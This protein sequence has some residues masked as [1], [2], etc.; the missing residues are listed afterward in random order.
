MTGT[1]P[2]RNSPNI[3]FTIFG[4]GALGSLVGGKLAAGFPVILIGRKEHLTAIEKQGLQISGKS[5]LT[6]RPR[7][8]LINEKGGS[9]I[10]EKWRAITKSVSKGSSY[11]TM[12]ASGITGTVPSL[13]TRC[14]LIVAY[15]KTRA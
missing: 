10:G 3:I 14:T 9:G 5:E 2:P 4:A 6:V 11:R 12:G 7:V 1:T 13:V 15:S 8:V